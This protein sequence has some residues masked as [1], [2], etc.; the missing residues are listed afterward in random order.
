MNRELTNMNII[1]NIQSR[2]NR[3]S[4]V[5]QNLIINTLN[6]LDINYNL[7]DEEKHIYHMKNLCI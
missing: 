1:D 7:T 4:L 3:L 6:R 2:Y 5:A